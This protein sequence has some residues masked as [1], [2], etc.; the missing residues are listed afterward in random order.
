MKYEE[1]QEVIVYE[2]ANRLI[3]AIYPTDAYLAN[4]E[5]FDMLIEQYNRGKAKHHQIAMA[6]L[7]TCEFKKNHNGKILRNQVREEV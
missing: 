3:A 5:Y 7:R 6:K 4:Q 2:E 1:I